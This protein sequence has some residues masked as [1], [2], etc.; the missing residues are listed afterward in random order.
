MRNVSMPPEACE[1][2]VIAT[3][4]ERTVANRTF[5]AISTHSKVLER[6]MP[7][8]WASPNVLPLC[9]SILF[10]VER[11]AN[12]TLFNAFA[13]SAAK[14]ISCPPIMR[15]L[16][17]CLKEGLRATAARNEEPKRCAIKPRPSDLLAAPS[18]SAR[19][20]HARQ[21]SQSVNLDTKSKHLCPPFIL[22][23]TFLTESFTYLKG[24]ADVFKATS[25]QALLDESVKLIDAH[26]AASLD[27]RDLL[28]SPI[29]L[30]GVVDAV[31]PFINAPKGAASQDKGSM[32]TE[33]ATVAYTCDQILALLARLAVDSM[34][35]SGSTAIVTALMA[36]VPPTDLTHQST[37]RTA[38]F[39]KI[40]GSVQNAGATDRRVIEEPN[41]AAAFAAFLEQSSDEILQGSPLEETL[42]RVLTSILSALHS[43][44]S[45]VKSSR[46]V[47]SLLASLNRIVLYRYV[48]TIRLLGAARSNIS[49]ALCSG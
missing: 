32:D 43:T 30:R 47:R 2:P 38:L 28:F 15:A 7:R 37:F 14:R 34:L 44:A 18:S 3:H 19:P 8:F 10:G 46:T 1:S 26:C 23:L 39:H 31:L 36:A 25:E 13:P 33:L 20:R 41:A 16:I 4:T 9:W 49:S 11:P 42:F 17:A 24:L 29:I 5:L 6:L 35:A 12:T 22:A 27:F 40:L 21:R 48:C 45:P